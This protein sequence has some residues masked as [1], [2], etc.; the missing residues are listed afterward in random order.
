MAQRWGKSGHIHVAPA[1][2]DL[3][4]EKGR[5]P[6]T[7]TTRR[8]PLKDHKVALILQVVSSFS[9]KSLSLMTPEAQKKNFNVPTLYFA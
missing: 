6:I 8:A 9:I 4:D 3:Q 7:A 1:T 2:V 5:L